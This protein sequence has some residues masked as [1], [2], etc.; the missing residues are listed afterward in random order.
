MIARG[1]A[2]DNAAERNWRR[3]RPSITGA[4]QRRRKKV[5]RLSRGA[6][7]APRSW[8]IGPLANELREMRRQ[9]DHC[10]SR[11]PP[12]MIAEPGE[13]HWPAPKF[14]GRGPARPKDFKISTP[15]SEEVVHMCGQSWQRWVGA[16]GGGTYDALCGP[17]VYAGIRRR[18]RHH[19]Q[20][21]SRKIPGSSIRPLKSAGGP[22]SDSLVGKFKRLAPA[23]RS[24]RR[25]S[26]GF[27]SIGGRLDEERTS[28]HRRLPGDMGTTRFARTTFFAGLLGAVHETAMPGMTRACREGLRSSRWGA[29]ASRA[30][31]MASRCR[32]K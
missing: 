24:Q 14:R 2:D 29:T 21:L 1:S 11:T 4:A 17:R 19:L 27:P 7:R 10:H 26:L 15:Q 30:R 6:G 16:G 31:E 3:S 28:V 8:R 18:I 25:S 9:R 5:A 13:G 23:L 12:F 22:R 32:S 20:G